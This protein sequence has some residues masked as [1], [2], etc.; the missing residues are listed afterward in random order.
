[1]ALYKEH[2]L[3]LVKFCKDFADDVATE[4]GIDPPT[5]VNLDA[6]AKMDELA[7]ADL[8]GLADFAWIDDDRLRRVSVS[9]FISTYADPDNI[10]HINIMDMLVDKLPPGSTVPIYAVIDDVVTRV[11]WMAVQAGLNVEPTEHDGTRSVQMLNLI[12][13]SGDSG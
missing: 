4:L 1:M 12:L 9:I 7:K 13:M 3:S 8:V 10:R 5:F 11:S 2:W 6:H